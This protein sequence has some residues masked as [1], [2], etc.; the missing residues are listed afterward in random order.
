MFVFLAERSGC[1]EPQGLGGGCPP[2]GGGGRVQP[3]ERVRIAIRLSRQKAGL[4][5]LSGEELAP[6]IL[7]ASFVCPC[8][9]FWGGRLVVKGGEQQR[10]EG[11]VTVAQE[12]EPD[13]G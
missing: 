6:V 4:G 11:W 12:F 10:T 9:F 5:L 8:I 7:G 13:L 3:A 1:P 2:S